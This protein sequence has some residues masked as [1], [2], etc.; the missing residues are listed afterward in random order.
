M[1]K[2]R[3][4]VEDPLYCAGMTHAGGKLLS[5][6]TKKAPTKKR[7][8]SPTSGPLVQATARLID[9]EGKRL[10]AAAWERAQAGAADEAQGMTHYVEGLY[11]ALELLGAAA[12]ALAAK[13]SA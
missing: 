8:R 2:V 13:P 7:G 9:E 11:R 6:P 10:T 5:F 12:R 1:Q 4:R 3:D